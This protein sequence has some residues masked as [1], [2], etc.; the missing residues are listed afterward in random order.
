MR[1]MLCLFAL[2]ICTLSA[3][4]PRI[5]R[6]TGAQW[7][8]APILSLT[9]ERAWCADADAVGCDFKRPASVRAL[10]DGGILA[11]DAQGPL[12]RFGADG[13]FV[14]ALGRR[15]QGPGEYG[16][17]VQASLASN[18]FVTW[19]DNSQ[20]RIA[21]VRLDGT[22][23]PVTR[24]TP[25]YTMALMFLVDTSLVVLDVPA[26][27]KVGEMVDATYRTVPATGTPRILARLR[28]PS[29][30]TIGSDMR[31]MGGPFDARVIGDVGPS[32]DVAHSN[33][34]RYEVEMFPTT[35]APWRLEIDAPLRTVTSQERDS[36]LAAVTRRF[37]VT[38]PNELPPAVREAYQAHRPNHPPLSHM[39]VLRDGTVWIRPTPAAGALTARWDVF[40][41]DAKRLGSASL[42]IAARVWDGTRDWVL[43]NELDQDDISRFVLY[44]VG[45]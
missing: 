32:G 17:V 21:T 10:P 41:R 24:L 8:A 9:R 1:L 6:E 11:A 28:T 18:G 20:M 29:T 26:A 39:K 25:P 40:A 30:F 37:R 12:H 22:A 35:G 16:F 45:R 13:R 5:V 7:R 27:A 15:G 23:G 38:I 44:R 36:A 2:P 43:V 34:A 42:P 33:G 4:S 14:A 19:F 3:Q 31:S